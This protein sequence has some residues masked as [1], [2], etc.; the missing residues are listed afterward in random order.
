MAL[1][2]WQFRI[3]SAPVNEIPCPAEAPRLYVLRMAESKAHAGAA[4]AQT[5]EL[6]IGSDTIV[7]DAARPGEKDQ[8]VILGKPADELEA[9]SMLRRLRGRFHQV[10]TAVAVYRPADGQLIAELCSTTVKMRTY[11]D[12]EI[13]AY[14]ASGDPLDKAGAYAIQHAEF[15]PVESLQGCFANV[16]GLPL[17]LLNRCLALFG[18][19]APFNIPQEC[20]H[21]TCPFCQRIMRD[22]L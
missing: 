18:L 9:A 3:Q 8:A 1:G 20:N 15:N 5:E 6:V 16:I 12:A 22:N 11:T 14:V 13:A 10:M 19:A 17:C 7:V 4:G 2:G 21:E